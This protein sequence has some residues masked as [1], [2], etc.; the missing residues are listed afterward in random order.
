[1]ARH[2]TLDAALLAR[3][4]IHPATGLA[5]DY[6]NYFNE[7]AMLLQMLADMPDMAED[8]LTWTPISY[9]EHFTRSNFS[10]RDLAIRAHDEAAPAVRAAFDAACQAVGDH[11]SIVQTLLRDGALAP[12][13][14]ALEAETLCALIARADGVIHGRDAAETAAQDDIDALFA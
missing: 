7:P 8:V 1:M 2:P 3:A 9:A 14:A 13:A 12:D 4:N 10:E 6:L 11:L 5:T